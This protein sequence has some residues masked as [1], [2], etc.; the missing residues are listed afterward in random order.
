MHSRN[1]EII[2][3]S[4]Q[5]STRFEGTLRRGRRHSKDAVS[6]AGES[7]GDRLF[8]ENAVECGD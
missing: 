1:E 8:S 5:A 4:A 6:A 2:I 7:V 3:D